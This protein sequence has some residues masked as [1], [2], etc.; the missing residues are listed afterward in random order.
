MVKSFEIRIYHFQEYTYTSCTIPWA[1]EGRDEV[2]A[3]GEK[4]KGEKGKR[5]IWIKNR[6]KQYNNKSIFQTSKEKK[7]KKKKYCTQ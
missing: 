5:N 6:V 1:G 7:K 3:A 2:M 4:I